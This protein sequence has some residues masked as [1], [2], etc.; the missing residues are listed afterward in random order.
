MNRESEI[1]GYCSVAGAKLYFE[2]K[3]TGDPI[4]FCHGSAMDRRIWDEQ[5][6]SLSS[7][8]QIVRFDNRG[9]GKSG[10]IGAGSR[11]YHDDLK[12]LLDHLHISKAVVAGLSV[13]GGIALNFAIDHAARVSGLLLMGTFRFW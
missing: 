1:T 4:V 9:C 3:G 2:S 11:M 10:N 6:S 7:R 8:F 12:A 5:Y 13:G